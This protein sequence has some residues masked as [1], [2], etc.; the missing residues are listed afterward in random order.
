MMTLGTY[1][2][3]QQSRE[4]R[5][6]APAGRRVSAGRMGPPH[7][8]AVAARS[9]ARTQTTSAARSMPSPPG[10]MPPPLF[11]LN[12]PDALAGLHRKAARPTPPAHRRDHLRT[13]YRRFYTMRN[14]DLY[15]NRRL[16]PVHPRTAA[17]AGRPLLHRRRDRQRRR[18]KSLW[19]Q[20]KTAPHPIRWRLQ[21]KPFAPP[22]STPSTAGKARRMAV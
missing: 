15:C 21:K 22:F 11:G 18:K 3:A 20:A 5:S 7:R 4:R 17:Q 12:A 9:P 13:E 6:P 14:N 16:C 2:P 10:R 8:A 1:P 19:S